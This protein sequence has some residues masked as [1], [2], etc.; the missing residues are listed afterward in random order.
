MVDPM[1]VLPYHDPF[2]DIPS[3]ENFLMFDENPNLGLA[4]VEPN[5]FNQ[6]IIQSA[7]DITEANDPLA[8]PIIWGNYYPTTATATASNSQ[9]GPSEFCGE[10]SRRQEIPQPPQNLEFGNP[11]QLPI[12]PVPPVPYSCTCCQ[13]LRE[14]IHTNGIHVT[15]LEI[16]GRL[17]LICHAILE[18]QPYN[19]NWTTGNQY[20]MFDFCKK[21]IE[22][23]REF[24]IQY[25]EERKQG[26]YTMLQDPLLVFYEALCVGLNGEDDDLDRER[27]G[28]LTVKD[29]IGYFHIPIEEAAKK[30]NI[31]PTVM[32]KICRKYG[33]S[34]WPYRKIR[35]IERQI[36]ERRASLSA[37]DAE[38][39]ARA[40][41]DI[42]SLQQTLASFFS[43]F[44]D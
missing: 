24:L 21:S 32:K 12:W 18:T 11:V 38:E 2:D 43:A 3:L 1:A 14:I 26:G 25:C 22:C 30:L 8:D 29:L 27:T 15:K 19:G 23:V 37:R 5:S 35:S 9:A 39:R 40:Q 33:L 20:H 44:A 34:R 7:N 28:K 17:G 6:T 31:C 42:E 41:A 16:H 10:T 36:S 4:V 13:V